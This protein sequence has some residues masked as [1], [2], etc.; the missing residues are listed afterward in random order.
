MSINLCYASRVQSSTR[1]REREKGEKFIGRACID[2]EIKLH[3]FDQN[4]RIG[5]VI[6]FQM[7]AGRRRA[8]FA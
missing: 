1:E 8:F 2:E 3:V 7:M 4:A 5:R 6:C